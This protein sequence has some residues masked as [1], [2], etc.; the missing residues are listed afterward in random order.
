VELNELLESNGP[1]SAS[2]AGRLID[3]G[4]DA[5]DA[6]DAE[7]A[8]NYFL[9]AAETG[10]LELAGRGAIGAAESLVRLGRDDEAVELLEEAAESGD[11]EVRF[12]ARRRLAVLHVTAGKLPQALSEYQRAERDAPTEAARAE[13]AARI[14]W[15][16]QETGGSKLRARLAFSRS[17]SGGR[18]R[19]LPLAMV[20]VTAVVSVAAL[21]SSA[22]LE[23][24]ALIKLDVTRG[25]LL[26]LRSTQVVDAGSGLWMEGYRLRAAGS[27]LEAAMR[28]IPEHEDAE[29]RGVDSVLQKAAVELRCG[30]DLREIGALVVV[31]ERVVDGEGQ[32]GKRLAQPFVARA[33]TAIDQVAGRQQQVGLRHHAAQLRHHPVESLAVELAGAVRLEAQVDIGDLRDEHPVIPRAS[34]AG[35]VDG[36]AENDR[37]PKLR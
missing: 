22:I 3:A 5:L 15:L 9:R 12:V 30:K 4:A 6:G 7:L 27:V 33:V 28:V 13:I 31:A 35:L 10:Q 26:T 1:I 20:G 24:L 37:R 19:L 14:G 25:D 18:E 36:V 23:P 16:T 8:L 11:R 34:S 32:T 21:A 2:D 17:R 29:G